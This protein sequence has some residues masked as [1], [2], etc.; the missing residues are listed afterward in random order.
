[1]RHML[2]RSMALVI[3]LALAVL[4]VQAGSA[5]AKNDAR[6]VVLL[7]HDAKPYEEALEGFRSYFASKGLEARIDVFQLNGDASGAARALE[8]ARDEKANLILTLGSLATSAAS[9]EATGI[10]VV[11]GLIMSVEEIKARDQFAAVLLDFPLEV[12]LRWIVRMLP[13]YRNIGILYNPARM[14]QKVEA[15]TRIAQGMG[16]KVIAQ[17]VESPSELPA[18]LEF[19]S[20]KVDLL[21]GIADDLVYTPQTAK[22]ILL[23][24][25]RNRIPLVGISREWVKA[26]ALYAIESDYRDLGMQCGEKMLKVIQS[27]GSDSGAPEYPRKVVYSLNLKTAQHMKV[28]IGESLIQGA[29]QVFK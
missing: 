7:S 17:K 14:S 26:G 28:E 29:R 23:F 21:W 13:D 10:P 19:L 25:F 2:Q 9:A 12:Q 5:A 4:P 1:M 18:A 27:T 11:A 24:S 6:V 20:K 22:E 3:A 8:K 16:L 15:A